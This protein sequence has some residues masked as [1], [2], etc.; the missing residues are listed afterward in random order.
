M[1]LGTYTDATAAP[2]LDGGSEGKARVPPTHVGPNQA[3][4]WRQCGEQEMNISSVQLSGQQQEVDLY[5]NK[6]IYFAWADHARLEFLS[7]L[8]TRPDLLD[9]VISAVVEESS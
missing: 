7:S 1:S 6:S 4:R 9:P 5:L 8:V 3:K 2:P